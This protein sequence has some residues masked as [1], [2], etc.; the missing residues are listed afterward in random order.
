MIKLDDIR[1]HA[2]HGATRDAL[3]DGQVRLTW[4][5]F[6][7]TVESVAAGLAQRLP[8]DGPVRAVFLAKN[9]W[10]LT[11]AMS[12]CATLG[13]SCTGLDADTDPDTLASVLTRLEPSFVFSDSDRRTVLDRLVRPTGPEALHI[14]LDGTSQ[15]GDDPDPAR[16]RTLPFDR[17]TSTEPLRELPAPLPYESFAI[18]DDD[19]GPVRIAVR[20]TPYE[21]RHLVDLVDEFGLARS[22]VHLASAPL[23]QHSALALTRTALGVGATV[24]L[25]DGADGPALTALLADER[26]TTAT[27]GPAALRALLAQPA[28]AAPSPRTGHLRFL[29]TPARQLGTWAVNTAWERLGP[30]LHTTLGSPETGLTAVLGPEELLVSPPHSGRTTLGTTVVVLG[31]DGRVLPQGETGRLG[32]AGHQVMDGYLD[33]DAAFTTLDHGPGEERFLL[34]G[35]CGRIDGTGRLQVTGRTTGV[36]VQERGSAVDAELFRLESDLLSLPCLRDTAVMRVSSPVLGDAIVVPFIAVAV[37]REATGYEALS[38]ACAR[39]VPSLAAHV[40]AVD[41]IPYSPT[42]RIRSGELLDAVLPIITL[43]LQLEQSMQQEMST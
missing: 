33:G 21:G 28:D 26:V 13:V 36:P 38:A 2:A 1:R 17:L 6:G 43:N 27:V 16:R 24:V 15:P 12:A 23:A 40:I 5:R 9:T 32:F 22:D 41:T 18:S 30:V 35:Q 7:D 42:G 25:A 39:R 10:Q 37:G 34:T 3:I 8:A 29:A 31:E 11:V 19:A 14:L 4:G 20:R